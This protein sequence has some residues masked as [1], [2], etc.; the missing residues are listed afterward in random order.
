MKKWRYWPC[1]PSCGQWIGRDGRVLYDFL[2]KSQNHIIFG[3][4]IPHNGSICGCR[5]PPAAA[6]SSASLQAGW[7]RQVS[8]L[9][10]MWCLWYCKVG[11][12]REEAGF[13]GE[14]LCVPGG[15]STTMLVDEFVFLVVVVVGHWVFAALWRRPWAATGPRISSLSF[16]H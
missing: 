9:W 10:P 5:R 2:V 11:N 15:E 16:F 1:G 8:Q 4:F 14:E 12:G 3:N 6:S 13:C 7:G